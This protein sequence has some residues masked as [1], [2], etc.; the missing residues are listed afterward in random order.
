MLLICLGE[1]LNGRVA[2][3]K[4]VGCVFESRLPCQV[5]C[6]LYYYRLLIFFTVEHATTAAMQLF[7]QNAIGAIAQRS[8]FRRFAPYAPRLPCHVKCSLYYYRL[9]IF[10]PLNTATDFG[11]LFDFCKGA[12][13]FVHG[14]YKGKSVVVF[15]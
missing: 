6:S 15:F 14:L 8:L 5:K 13:S 3:S 9:L 7:A 10:L 12:E 4:T 11:L 2:V 1:W